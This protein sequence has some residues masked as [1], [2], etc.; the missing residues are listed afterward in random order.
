MTEVFLDTSALLPLLD[1]N[2]PDHEAVVTTIRKLLGD[3]IRFLTTSYI[4][5]EAGALVRRRLGRDAF[6]KLGEVIHDNVE[7]IW[8][9][10]SLHREAWSQAAG[11]PRSGPGLVDWTSFL[12]MKKYQIS[13]ALTL[14]AHFK[15]QGFKVLP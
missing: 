1:S 14:D 2:D 13:T 9:D 6:V 7:V 3:G 10:E 12:V 4:T 11:E 15:K 8:P 5:V